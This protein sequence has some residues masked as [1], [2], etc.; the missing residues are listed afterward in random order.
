MSSE[1][2]D[3]PPVVRASW[4][5]SSNG[6]LVAKGVSDTDKGGGWANDTIE[7]Q[8]GS[9]Q[10]D[11]NRHYVLDVDFAADRSALAATDPH[12]VVGITSDFVEGEMWI[13]YYLFFI[14]SAVALVGVA[15]L[16]ASAARAIYRRRQGQHITS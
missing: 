15:L 2:C 3:M 14:C 1:K 12:L 13:S 10:G 4:V 11:R 7:R 8:I 16:I 9:F 5:L 6:A